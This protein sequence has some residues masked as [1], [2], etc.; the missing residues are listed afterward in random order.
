[1]IEFSWSH[2]LISQ[3]TT[4]HHYRLVDALQEHGL[5]FAASLSPLRVG[6]LLADNKV[7][8]LAEGVFTVPWLT[9]E[10]CHQLTQCFPSSAYA[11]NQD[12]DYAAQIPEIILAEHSQLLDARLEHLFD[13]TLRPLVHLLTGQ[14]IV[15]ITSIQ[16]ARYEPDRV[17]EG[18]YHTDEDS[19]ITVT[20]PLNDDYLGGG[21]SIYPSFGISSKPAITVPKLPVGTATIFRGRTMLHKGL[22]IE[23]GVKHLLVFWM[24]V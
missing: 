12:E 11:P 17:K 23:A 14:P 15:D 20:V 8:Q 18:C 22:K 6:R 4:Q 9:P 24:K 1:M 16:L 3:D 10:F 5:P 2:S 13:M 19:D 7:T 21:L